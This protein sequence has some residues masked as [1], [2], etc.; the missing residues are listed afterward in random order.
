MLLHL[1]FFPPESDILVLTLLLVYQII[2]Q[3]QKVLFSPPK[4]F[5]ISMLK[6]LST[7][8]KLPIPHCCNKIANS[9]IGP[10]SAQAFEYN[11]QIV[12][13]SF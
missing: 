10:E 3:G 4:K 13:S 1:K 12:N 6:H 2:L 9:S 8:I 7:N 11:N 5:P